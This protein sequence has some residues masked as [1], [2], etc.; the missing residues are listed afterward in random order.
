MKRHKLSRSKSK[1]SF[2]KHSKIKGKNNWSPMRGGF[3][4]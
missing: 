4:M 2:A 1:R 3:R